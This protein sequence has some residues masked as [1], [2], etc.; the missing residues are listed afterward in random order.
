MPSCAHMSLQRYRISRTCA[1]IGTHA[2]HPGTGPLTC[3]TSMPKLNTLIVSGAQLLIITIMLNRI[4]PI[5]TLVTVRA[6]V[7][8]PLHG[9]LRCLVCVW[10]CVLWIEE[11][12]SLREAK[13]AGWVRKIDLW[14]ARRPPGST[15][16]SGT[17][18]LAATKKTPGP[19]KKLLK[20]LAYVIF[21]PYLCTMY[22][23]SVIPPIH[24]LLCKPY[25][26]QQT[27]WKAL[28]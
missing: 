12:K 4:L 8:S 5:N 25:M 11:S 20:K 2:A 10:V 22:L 24:N 1:T 17:I 28:R 19:A 21:N 6:C 26:W 3:R 13:E 27:P 16:L 23:I 15:T 18:H 7:T 14:S 9:R